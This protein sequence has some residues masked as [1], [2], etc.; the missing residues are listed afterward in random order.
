MQSSLEKDKDKDFYSYFNIS[1]FQFY[2]EK[3]IF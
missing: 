3:L 2:I 1:V